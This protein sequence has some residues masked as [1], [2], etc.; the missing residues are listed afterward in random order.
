MMTWKYTNF[1]QKK[2]ICYCVPC[3]F[4][5]FKWDTLK[6]ITKRIRY[7]NA[8]YWHDSMKWTPIY[9]I[10][11]FIYMTLC[12]I[13]GIMKLRIGKF[14]PMV[15]CE[16]CNIYQKTQKRPMTWSDCPHQILYLWVLHFSFFTSIA[17][18]WRHD[19]AIS[20]YSVT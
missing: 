18:L 4:L 19:H 6:Q 15:L 17:S 7:C 2:L 11:V 20:W 16:V 12:I 14:Y 9:D 13:Y 10:L 8:K 5:S 1:K 3:Y